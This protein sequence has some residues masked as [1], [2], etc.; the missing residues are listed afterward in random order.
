MGC[1][2]AVAAEWTRAIYNFPDKF[3]ASYKLT[4]SQYGLL[5]CDIMQSWTW[6]HVSEYTCYLHLSFSKLHFPWFWRV[7]TMVFNTQDYCFFFWT[8]PSSGILETWKQ[9]VS[10]TGSVSVLRWEGEKTPT[11]LD[12][13]ERANLNHWTNSVRL[14][15]LFNYWRPE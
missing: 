9:D 13:L 3:L 7:P 11:Q 4:C 5:D 6:T 12:H 8:F 15:Q 10:E 14:T 2:S 1:P